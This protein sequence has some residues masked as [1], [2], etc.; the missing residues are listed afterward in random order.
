MSARPLVCAVVSVLVCSSCSVTKTEAP[1]GAPGPKEFQT[2]IA[3]IEKSD[4]AS[5]AALIAR[6]SY[7]EFLLDDNDAAGPSCGERLEKAQEQLGSVNANPRSSVMFP[8]GWARAVDIESRLHVARAECGSEADRNNELRTAI[9]AAHRAV[10]LYR[11]MFDY[12]SMVVMQFDMAV[13]LRRLGENA[14]ALSALQTVLD[15]DREYGFDDDAR[16]NYAVLLT[17]KDEPADDVHVA[18]LMQDFPKRQVT[19][20]FAWR[21]ADAR[22]RFESHRVS[23]QGEQTLRSRASAEFERRIVADPDKGW[24]VSYSHRLTQYEPGVWP[25]MESSQEPPTVFSAAPLPVGFNV[26]AAGEF[27]RVNEPTDFSASMV[28][29]TEEL[30]RAATPAGKGTHKLAEQAVDTAMSYLSPGVLEATAAENYQLETAMWI[31]STLEQG[32]WHEISA[33]LSL[34]GMPRVVVQNHLQFA[35]THRVP[36]SD[37]AP[38]RTCAEIVIRAMPDRGDLDQVLADFLLPGTGLHFRDYTASTEARIV[39]DPTTLLPYAREERI[40]WY[41]SIGERPQDTLIRSEHLVS[42]IR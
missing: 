28:A 4:P 1:S 42:R 24:N 18:Q 41:V 14:G 27:D 16:E 7:A 6:L 39:V 29:K 30:I 34:P 21:P 32:V 22:M 40:Y 10:E 36:C 26:S 2:A 13:A 11:G 33:P 37:G 3:G 8:D 25:V 20:T 35:F 23:L 12:R 17:W 5:P 15:M 19:L 9:A 31:G 38:A